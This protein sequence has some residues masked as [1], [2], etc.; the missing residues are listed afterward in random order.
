[1]RASH[2][3]VEIA[4]D[5]GVLLVNLLSRAALEL[6]QDSFEI[7]KQFLDGESADDDPELHRFLK[8][9]KAGF[10]LI[11]DSFDELKYLRERV[12]R[13]RYDT[14]TLQLVI[15]PTMGCNFGCHYCFED[16]PNVLMD[17]ETEA[18]LLDYVER[19][20]SGKTALAVQWFGGEPLQAIEQL[21]RISIGLR[22]AAEARSASYS[23]AI[24]TNGYLLGG[25]IPSLLRSLGIRTAQ[26]TLDGDKA[27]HDR[28]RHTVGGGGSF[29]TVLSNIL[30]A[31]RF[32]DVALRIHV[33]P[34]NVLS[35]KHLLSNLAGRNIGH[36]VKEIY[37]A[38]LF[39]YKP[40]KTDPQFA[41]DERRFFDAKSFAA[42]EAELFACMKAL[43]LPMPDL[44]HAPFSVC[45][46]VRENAI[47]IGPSGNMYK[48]YFELDRMD[49]AVG[50]VRVGLK[51]SAHL[52]AWLSH[53][54]AR[55]EE[56]QGCKFLPVC[57][58]GC[59]HKWQQRAPKDVIC[60]RLR[61]NS[62]QVL[63]LMFSNTPD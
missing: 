55:D 35:V 50:D 53:D 7:F 28:T 4:M 18:Q 19:R 51:E 63:P 11:E 31:A 21:E 62:E 22:R 41:P 25:E 52:Q 13:E 44:L 61:F 46:A 54:I 34:F 43:G 29:E 37:F 3:N 16:R 1:M 57:F 27:L 45:T 15:A 26:I 58:G 23:A 8:T 39:N 36:A 17:S 38:P 14:D 5:G 30:Q 49:R 24:V 40:H 32:I 20:L 47:V 59:T 42:V 12:V 10:F 2:Y 6:D 33:A 56:C 48:C 9:L 60:T